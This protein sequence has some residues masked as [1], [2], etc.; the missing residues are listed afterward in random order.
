MINDK[1]FLPVEKVEPVEEAEEYEVDE[2]IISMF[3]QKKDDDPKINRV[4]LYVA[5]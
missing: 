3:R 4:K 5:S 1:R 2:D